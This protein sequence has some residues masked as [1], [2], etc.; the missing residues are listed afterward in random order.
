MN[1]DEGYMGAIVEVY[2]GDMTSENT[3]DLS[4][5]M[6]ALNIDMNDPVIIDQ[7][8]YWGNIL[9]KHERLALDNLWLE[10]VDLAKVSNNTGI[11]MEYIE[12]G[13]Y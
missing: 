13:G 6:N 3:L 4:G 9:D 1:I 8:T 7:F 5:Y 2:T 12:T 11:T 10:Q